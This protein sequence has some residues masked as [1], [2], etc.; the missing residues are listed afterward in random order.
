MVE[1]VIGSNQLI[2]PDYDWGFL[3]TILTC[4][5]N[6]WV[7]KTTPEDWWN[8]ITFT[9]PAVIDQKSEV[10]SIREFFCRS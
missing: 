3:D 9:V 1:S 2:Y 10:S 7:L 6:R 5:H 8:I 4:Y